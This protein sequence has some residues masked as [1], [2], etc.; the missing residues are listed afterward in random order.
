MGTAVQFLGQV[1]AHDVEIGDFSNI[2]FNA[3]VLGHIRIGAGVNIAPGAVIGNGSARRP[4]VI[5][6]GAKV[7]PGAV[8]LQDVA[9][10]ETVVGNPAMPLAQWGRLQRLLR[11]SDG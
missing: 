6:D 4:M 9:A 5:G 3:T 10:G 1:A 2:G 7:G 11:G 8:V